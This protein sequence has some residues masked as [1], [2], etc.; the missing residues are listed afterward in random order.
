MAESGFWGAIGPIPIVGNVA[1]GAQAAYHA[2]SAVYDGVTG[3]RDGAVNHGTQALWSGVNAIPAVNTAL[4]T[5]NLVA[6]GLG[7]TGRGIVGAAGGDSSQVPGDLGDLLGTAA[8]GATNAI[9]GADD[10]N[11]IAP[12][13]T[14][15]GTRGGEIG[16]G[17]SAVGAGL[18]SGLGSMF[19]PLGSMAGSAVGGWAG[20]KLGNWL[21]DD[22]NAPTSGATP[23]VVASAGA[24]MNDSLGGTGSGAITGAALG[25]LL[26]PGI[27]TLA[28]AGLGAGLGALD[29]AYN[30]F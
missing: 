14:P 15:T 8:V 4:G 3:D 2:G 5:A 22:P 1:S 28:G 19:G 11:W 16:A 26:L 17:M 13:N 23:G 10:T 6:S 12:G 24:S 9:F 18:G 20:N 27:G 30:I 7:V 29:E 25:S 21:A